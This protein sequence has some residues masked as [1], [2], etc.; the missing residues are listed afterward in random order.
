MVMERRTFVTKANRPTVVG[1]FQS[2]MEA[3]QAMNDLEQAGFG[4]DQIRYSVHRGGTGVRDQLMD[5]GL[6][7]QEASYYNQEF[8]AGRTVVFVNAPDRQREAFD[9]LRRNGGYDASTDV[10]Q[11]SGAANQIT[12]TDQE[13]RMQLR[14]EQL[15]I[16]KQAVQSGEVGL[17]KELVSEQRTIDVPVTREEVVIERRPGSGQPS[18]TPIG[19]GETYRVPVREEQVSVQKQPVVR[20]EIT[21]GKRQVQDT[22]QVSEP[23]RREEAHIEREGDVNTQGNDIEGE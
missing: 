16:G 23:I 20:E 17:H 21:L 8:E 4:N 14:E 7:E 3:Q 2:E 12:A 19:E 15:R 5:L 9:I 1:L 6:T 18:D 10:T 11:T 13:Q 22:Q